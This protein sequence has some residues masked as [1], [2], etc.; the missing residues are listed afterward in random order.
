MPIGCA[1][2]TLSDER[3]AELVAS[4]PAILWVAANVHGNEKSG[5]DAALKVLYE[6]ADR[7][8][9]VADTV[10]DNAIVVI[11]PT[12]NPDGRVLGHASQPLRVRHEPRLVR[13]DAARDRRQSSTFYAS[14][15]RCSLSTLTSSGTPTI[16]F[17]PHADPEYHETPD[18]AH[19]WIF[20]DYSPAI[21]SAF[22]DEKLPYHHGA[23]Y[24]FFATI[25][26]DTVP[27]VGF[28]A[29][30]M[31]FEKDNRD[32]IS[33]RAF[34]QFL[35]MWSSVFQGATGGIRLRRAVACVLRQRLR[36]GL[37]GQLEPNAV[38]NPESTLYQDVHDV[39]VRH[40]FLETSRTGPTRSTRWYVGCSAWTSTFTGSRRRSDSSTSR[41][42]ATNRGRRRCRSV[43]TGSPWLRA[44][45]TG[46]SRCCTTSRTSRSR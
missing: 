32:L 10:L 2:Q 25:F 39:T 30:G 28:H 9:C 13:T 4:T 19:D 27:A 45:S 38:F 42:M 7:T 24:D 40:Y 44:R 15:R 31:T 18:T 29:A 14:S 22:D 8:D 6:L 17:P 46:S 33:D 20:D 16:Y 1:T 41:L 5:A 43:R 35:A 34:Q 26:G 23:P 12:Q 37:A 11:M 36:R 21:A 3:A